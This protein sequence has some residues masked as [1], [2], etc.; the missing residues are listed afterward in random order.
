MSFES[1]RVNC[2]SVVMQNLKTLALSTLCQYLFACLFKLKITLKN[3]THFLWCLFLRKVLSML[4]LWEFRAVT[5][6]VSENQVLRCHFPEQG[7]NDGCCPSLAVKTID[8]IALISSGASMDTY[9]GRNELTLLLKQGYSHSA[10]GL[11]Q[12]ERFSASTQEAQDPRMSFSSPNHSVMMCRLRKALGT[13]FP[14]PER[15]C[16][17]Q[18]SWGGAS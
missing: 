3:H 1:C 4:Y 17:A 8:N 15:R 2:S 13:G 16:H 14:G 5:K 18:Q 10:S 7:M 9:V 11:L 12:E 6:L